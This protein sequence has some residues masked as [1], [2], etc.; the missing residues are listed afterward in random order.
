MLFFKVDRAARNLFDYVELERL[1]VE[2]GVEVVYVTQP[3]ENTPAGRMMR[4]TLANMASF[5]TEQQSLDVKDGLFRRVQAGLFVG[6]APYGYKN[7]RRDGRSLVEVDPERAKIVRQVFDLYAFDGHT[8]ESLIE[9]L[10][11]EGVAYSPKQR[12]FTRS[13]L[14]SLLRDRSYVGEIPYKGQWYP[15]TQEPL[16]NRST[17]DRVQ[18]LLGGQ[19][20]RSH[21]LTYAGNLITCGHCGR[22]ITGES[23]KKRSKRGEKVYHYYRCAGYTAKGHPRVRLP[24]SKLDEQMLALF[25][26]L[27]ID[28]DKTHDWFACVLRERT[29]GQQQTDRERIDD[30]NRQLANVRRQQDGLLNLRLL[31]EIDQSTF[32]AK[33][34]ELRDHVGKLT[35]LIERQDRCRAEAGEIAIKAFEL[36]QTLKDKWLTADYRAKRRILEIVCLNFRLVDVTLEP[37]WRKP[38]DALAETAKSKRS[39]RYEWARYELGAGKVRPKEATAQE[40]CCDDEWKATRLG[41]SVLGRVPS[42]EDVEESIKRFTVSVKQINHSLVLTVSCPMRYPSRKFHGEH[43]TIQCLSDTNRITEVDRISS[44]HVTTY[45][46][47]GVASTKSSGSRVINKF[48]E[49]WLSFYLPDFKR[50]WAKWRI[51]RCYHGI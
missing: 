43:L 38:F 7:V 42:P 45:Q 13:K 33:S 48:Y 29:R 17:F 20:Y 41:Y 36:S 28:D 35:L 10:D 2:H 27:R 21:E 19:V 46:P 30:L 5:Y 8:L 40:C 11:S 15:G 12:R 25:D 51:R 22:P 24:E 47:L 6:K 26:R 1:E 16:V 3:T 23:I 9:R 37:E 50:R 49:P 39:R 32:A 14:H 4:R 34:T 31:E 44:G 18:Q